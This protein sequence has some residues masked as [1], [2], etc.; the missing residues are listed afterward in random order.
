MELRQRIELKKLLVPQMRQS[1]NILAMPLLHIKELVE[2]E[3][4]SNPLL[5][6]LRP[7]SCQVNADNSDLDFRLSLITKKVSLHDI[8]LRQLGMFTNNDEDFRI[9]QEI[10]GNINENGYLKAGL[11]GIA[12]A[13]GVAEEKVET[14]LKL[15]QGFEPAGIGARSISECLCKQLELANEKDPLLM[16]IAACHLE[17]VAKKNY[18]L[19]ARNLKIPP[20]NVEPLIKKILKLN[21]KPGRNYSS[22]EIHRVIPDITV[23]VDDDDES[24]EISVNNE[25]IPALNLN[26]AYKDMM[27]DEKIDS[28][29][30]EFLAQKYR[31]ALELLRAVS[32]RQ[33]TLRKIAEAVVEIQKEAVKEGLS[34]VK[35][36]TFAQVAQKTGMHETTVCRAVMNKYV[37]TP[38]GIVALR[39]FF[40]SRIHD[41]AGLCVSSNHVKRLIKELIDGEDKGRP[42]SDE[43]I[44]AILNKEKSLDISRRTV[45][46]YREELKILSS[47]FRKER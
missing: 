21:P 46:K 35:P 1:L 6:E 12:I 14:V 23:E 18:S 8:L 25:D 20:E 22:E 34:R 47:A 11:S 5:E 24:I 45:T 9:G 39:D 42:L 7:P 19:I 30:K 36:L 4:E 13:L 10:I 29:T 2:N 44:R 31:N 37:K 15:I 28:Q 27:K 41:K 26:Q 38:H 32:R 33:D 17:D 16:K 40:P 3:L 43:D